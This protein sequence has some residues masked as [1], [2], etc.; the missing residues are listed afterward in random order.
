MDDM[1]GMKRP[2]R[3]YF[4]RQLSMLVM[5]PMLLGMTSPEGSGT[6][7]LTGRS[8]SGRTVFKAELQDIAGMFEGGS[9]S[10]DEHVLEFPAEGDRVQHHAI[11]DPQNGVFTL[12]YLHPGMDDFKFFR[13]WAIPNSFKVISGDRSAGAVYEFEA[14][15]EGTEPRPDKG[16]ATSSI[17]LTCRLEYRI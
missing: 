8:A 11:W 13:M 2:M 4:L 12:S 3:A 14:V 15:F 16:H 17:R 5:V 10:I 7:Y 1:S 9:I 6:A